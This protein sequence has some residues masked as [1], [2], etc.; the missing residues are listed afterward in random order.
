M[1]YAHTSA[2]IGKRLYYCGGVTSKL[3]E[4]TVSDFFYLD[5]SVPLTSNDLQW[6][7]L[8]NIGVTYT[9][10]S[11]AVAGGVNNTKFVLFGGHMSPDNSSLVLVFD[12]VNRTWSKPTISG[13]PP[14]RRRETHAVIDTKGKMYIFGGFT[15]PF[16]DYPVLEYFNDLVILDTIN[17]TWNYG[18]NVNAPSPRRAYSATILP[19]GTIVYIGGMYANSMLVPFSELNL[20]D[21][22]SDL[23]SVMF[24]DRNFRY[25]CDP[26]FVVGAES[27]RHLAFRTRVS[28]GRPSSSSSSLTSSNLFIAAAAVASAVLLAGVAALMF[29]FLGKGSGDGGSSKREVESGETP[30]TG[31][32]G[33]GSNIGG[34]AGVAADSS[35]D[36]NK[37]V[38]IK[39][40]SEVTL[41]H[42][43]TGK[44]LTTRG[45][46]YS[47]SLQ[48]IVACDN[49]GGDFKNATWTVIGAN[50]TKVNNG[51]TIPFN[52]TIGFKHNEINGNLH[53]HPQSWVSTPKSR[54]QQ[55]ERLYFCGGVTSE[56]DE[57]TVSDFFYLDVSVVP[58]SS[59]NDFQW[60]DLT[61]IGVTYTSWGTAVAGGANSTEFVLFGG[62][63]SPDNSSLVLAFNTVNRTWY[64]PTISGV[65]PLR[66]RE[67][68]AVIDTKGMMYIFGGY[69]DSFTD[70]PVSK[71][72]N[73]LVILDTINWIWSYGSNVNA[74]SPR[75]A[76]S[77]TILSSG[78]IVYIGGMYENSTLVPFSELNLYDTTSDSWSVM[79]A[80]GSIPNPRNGHTAVLTLEE[81]IVIYGGNL[82]TENSSTT[83]S[84]QIEI[85]D[86]TTTPFSWSEPIAQASTT[87]SN[88]M[89]TT[90]TSTSTSTSTPTNQS[91]S[92]SS[93][94]SPSNLL[95]AAA[96]VG[97][98]AVLAAAAA[99]VSKFLRKGSG[100]GGSSR[101]IED[102]RG[103]GTASNATKIP[104]KYGSEVALIHVPTG[105]YLT[106]KGDKYPDVN[107]Y[108]AA[109][110]DL[111]ENFKNI[112]NEIWTVI[113]ANGT[114]VNE[115]DTFPFKT[116]IGFKH[117]ETEGNLHSHAK[118]FKVTPKSGLQQAT[119]C[120]DIN[121]DDDWLVQPHSS[122]SVDNASGILVHGDIVN[123][124]HITTNK[125]AL[126]SHNVL[127]DNGTQEVACNDAGQE[128]NRQW[129]IELI[130]KPIRYGSTVAL[131]HMSTNKY[132]SNSGV[133]Y[134]NQHQ[135]YMVVCGGQV[136]DFKNDLWTVVG[137]YDTSVTIGGLV[138]LNTAI[139][140]K[141]RATGENLH[142]HTFAYGKTLKSNQ[143]Q[144]TIF[145][146]ANADNNW[147]VREYRSPDDTGILF[148]KN[149]ISI[150]HVSTNGMLYSHNVLLDDQTQEVSCNGDGSDENNKWYIELVERPILYGSKVAIIHI[151]TGRYLSTKKVQTPAT[152]QYMAVCT[153]KKID[154]ANDV[155][156]VTGA[157][158]ESVTD[159]SSIKFNTVIGFKNQATSGILYSQETRGG[160]VT[161]KSN[162]QQ[163]TINP[164]GGDGGNWLLRRFSP[165]EE[166]DDLGHFTDGDIISLSHIITGNK[167]LF[168]HDV[169]LDDGTREVSCNGDG[170]QENNKVHELFLNMFACAPN[171]GSFTYLCI[172]LISSS[173]LLN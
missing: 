43:P 91:S 142:S 56:A 63:M 139:G 66:R 143:Q 68:D 116:I 95:I 10:W 47:D 148:N 100:D 94:T 166:Y 67:T 92:T 29:R 101:G 123:L 140:F 55:G 127:L 25:N 14:L 20:Y 15:D 103:G 131:Y 32:G 117:N 112:K 35:G 4:S 155:W 121:A 5:V 130:S 160:N 146:N 85:L 165:N 11:T 86:T 17:W 147:I 31:D 164:G 108:I 170:H 173:G 89:T 30:D 96:A 70:Y 81:K 125:P 38:P 149:S 115:G 34:G 49:I 97:S 58:L 162:Q 99:L 51:D 132:L 41:V 61:S 109:C 9:S 106:T 110:D 120:L 36:A 24:P 3:K 73:D 169:Q 152:G 98:A 40:G 72:F 138:S 60:T 136:K 119:I 16:T 78:V 8:T 153:D 6:T 135:Q 39:Y 19:N 102:G 74:P 124:L 12:T 156:T 159:G 57:P 76:F 172:M 37:K 23:W 161:P 134:P 65:S 7:D 158:G 126:Y 144:V 141:H 45:D 21:T 33:G 79:T 50:G 83:N 118:S 71:Y 62:H 52:T 105:K 157:Y 26:F 104:I 122:S 54:L 171:E 167:P 168:S 129:R 64:K 113:G 69:T 114:N 44:Y 84:S 82:T 163:V 22:M 42:V 27:S 77:A 137:A 80:G 46:K 2:L 133:R 111:G 154:L 128:E 53:S 18:S 107:Q 59:T 88:S 145:P 1:R 48:Y 90:G 93:L 150:R 13:V 28:Y 75:R 87:E 151:P